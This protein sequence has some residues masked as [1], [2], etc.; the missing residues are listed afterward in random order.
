M[1][2]TQ[3]LAARILLDVYNPETRRISIGEF[4][5]LRARERLEVGLQ[6]VIIEYSDVASLQGKVLL[7]ARSLCG[8]CLAN[9]ANIA[10]IFTLCHTIFACKSARVSW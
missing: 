3:S 4:G 7:N 6:T 8:I 10:A 2:T 9:P 1:A 5:F